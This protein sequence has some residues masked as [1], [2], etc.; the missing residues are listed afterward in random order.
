[1]SPTSLPERPSLSLYNVLEPKGVV[2]R[3]NHRYIRIR[4]PRRKRRRT[5]KGE[6]ARVRRHTVVVVRLIGQR[7]AG[8]HPEPLPGF[9]LLCAPGYGA[10]RYDVADIH[11]HRL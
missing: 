1:M 10:P 8:L 5:H 4:K 11:D 6:V 7:G 2:D 3:D 9:P